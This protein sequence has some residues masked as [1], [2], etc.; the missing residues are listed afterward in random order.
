MQVDDCMFADIKTEIKEPVGINILSLKDVAGTT[1]QTQEHRFSLGKWDLTYEELQ[2]LV[3][4][5]VNSQRMVV[6][7]SVN[8]RKKI[9][10]YLHKESWIIPG[11]RQTIQEIC[12]VLG[13]L[14][15]AVKLSP[16][17]QSPTICP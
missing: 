6:I 5:D 9:L 17:G 13:I 4:H 2:L 12:S 3:G 8:S 14:N 11:Y 7:I 10:C 15:Y 16:L 1:H